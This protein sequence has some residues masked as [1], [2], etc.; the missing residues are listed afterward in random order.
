[1]DRKH[2]ILFAVP[3][4]FGHLHPSLAIARHLL[5]Q[6]HAVGYCSGSGAKKIV[7]SYGI[8]DFY[9]RDVYQTA[10]DKMAQAK[11][12]YENWYT[13]ARQCSTR[14]IHQIFVELI[15]AFEAF[16]PDVVYVDSIDF[17]AA[18]VADKYNLPFAH[19]SATTL[20]YFEKDI[21]PLGTGWDINKLWLNRFR[22]IP[23][24][25]G[26]VPFMLKIYFNQLKAMK[27]IDV[28]WKTTNLSGI[29]PYLFMLFSTDKFEYPR[30]LFIPSMFY[31]G[32]SILEPDEKQLLDFPWEKLDD[33]KPLI[34]IATGTVFPEIYF[35]FYKKIM[36]ALSELL[37]PIQVQ[38]VMA[39]G[40]GQSVE[41]LG[42]IP[43]NF[44]VVNYA[45]QVKL[46]EKASVVVTHG[47]VNSVNEALSFGK[48][49]LVVYLGR[50]LIEMAQRVVH[51]GAGIRLDP[52]KATVRSIRKKII[53]LLKNPK[54]T[55]SA[56]G[57]MHSFNKCGGE[58]TAAALIE[59]L[60]ETKRPIL[61]K[62]ESPITLENMNDLA[63]FLDD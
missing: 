2:R 21:P 13:V 26:T 36:K 44:I 48:P 34:Y 3:A 56:E 10:M 22:F 23:Y 54:Y 35:E 37:F 20:F 38:V 11:G 63:Q 8:N 40:R 43:K 32:P 19:G 31:V 41:A 6:G 60:A 15:D 30:K 25:M 59:R 28:N 55:R 42:N 14:V 61:R 39:I 57:V 50:D 53:Q 29:S 4:L 27:S 9:P 33:A 51:N 1:M 45:P 18:A 52:R 62:K 46:M 47:G 7:G 5:A 16:Q 49:M 24:V 58:K 12:I 17:F